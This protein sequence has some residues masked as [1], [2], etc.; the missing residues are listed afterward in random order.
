MIEQKFSI[1]IVE[2]ERLVA[3]DIAARLTQAGYAIAGIADNFDSAISLFAANLP[4]LVLLDINIKGDKNGIDIA[5]TINNSVPT[6]FIFVTAQTD[7][8]TLQKAKNTFP[9]AYLVKPFTTNHLT[10]SIDLALHNFA[11]QKSGTTEKTIVNGVEE[12]EE[13]IY[14]NQDF[15]FIKDG[16]TYIKINQKEV[17]MIE[18]EGNYVKIHTVEKRYLIRCTINK[19]IEKMKQPYFVRVHRSFCVNINRVTK[20]DEHDI[21]LEHVKVPI[22]RNYR[23]DFIKN[24][25]LL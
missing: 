25:D 12:E 19:A 6:P 7:A 5:T 14:L 23:E 21:I 3:K 8:D 1:L 13:N 2:D 9:S 15:V 10:V 11:Y 22:G 18:S 16:Q 17:L 20:F 4:D 24:F